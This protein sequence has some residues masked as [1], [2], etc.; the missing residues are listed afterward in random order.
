MEPGGLQ[1]MGSTLSWTHLSKH[2]H[3]YFS[4]TQQ[5]R[6]AKRIK[7]SGVNFSQILIQRNEKMRQKWTKCRW[8]KKHTRR[9][10][11]DVSPSISIV[12]QNQFSPVQ[13]L[14]CPTLCIPMDFSIPGLPV[15]HQ[16][17]EFIQTHVHWV[18]DAIQPS[19]PLSF[20]SPPAFNL[21]QHQGLFTLNSPN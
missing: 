13:S 10:N 18:G 7:S 1:S 21:S 6:C 16:L 20:R 11:A 12:T 14:S 8:D 9:K 17:P 5:A 2:T 19:H 4:T 15:H 3:T